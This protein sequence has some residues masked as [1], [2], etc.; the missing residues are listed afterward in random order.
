VLSLVV[1]WSCDCVCVT[2]TI[3]F[4]VGIVIC[5]VMGL[6]ID[7][8]MLVVGLASVVLEEC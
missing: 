5:D 4:V 1:G 8:I 3:G 6:T 2:I 7:E